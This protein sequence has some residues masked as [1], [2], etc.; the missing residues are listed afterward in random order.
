MVNTCPHHNDYG[1]NMLNNSQPSHEVA[2]G[3]WFEP[4]LFPKH[5]RRVLK[6]IG[7]PKG[8]ALLPTRASSPVPNV[9]PVKFVTNVC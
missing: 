2:A 4:N 6:G 5:K 3:S 7:R 1:K 8:R 9:P